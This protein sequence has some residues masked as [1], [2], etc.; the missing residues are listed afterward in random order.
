MRPTPIPDREI[1]PGAHRVVFGPP[2][3]DTSGRIAPVETLVDEGPESGYT[4]VSVRCALEPGDLEELLL[5]G[6]VWVT[7][8]GG[9]LQPFSVDVQPAIVPLQPTAGDT[10][11]DP[12]PD[13]P[14]VEDAAEREL[15]EAGYT[16]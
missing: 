12:D 10:P 5:G 4:R 3:D 7:F 14:A 16:N 13:P 11:A 1:W 9:G 8:Y 15:R 6:T 2:P